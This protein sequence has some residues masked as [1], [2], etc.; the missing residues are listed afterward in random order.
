MTRNATCLIFGALLVLFFTGALR[1][2]ALDADPPPSMS[3]DI[4]SDEAWWAHNARNRT[5]FG[6]WV[7]DDFNQGLFAPRCTRRW[8]G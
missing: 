7:L 2:V 6:K 3:S 5:L 8:L 4:A 1:V